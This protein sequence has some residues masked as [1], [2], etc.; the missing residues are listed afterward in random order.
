MRAK[1]VAKLFQLQ[2]QVFGTRETKEKRAK[3]NGKR[4]AK[5]RVESQRY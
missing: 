4:K 3:E 5:Q 2:T 1:I